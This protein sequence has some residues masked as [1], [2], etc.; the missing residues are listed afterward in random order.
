[1]LCFIAF[2]FYYNI[3]QF[4]E[5]HRHKCE[6]FEEDETSRPSVC[7]NWYKILS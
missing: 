2:Y 6:R 1:M 3:T 7:A 5:R 4:V